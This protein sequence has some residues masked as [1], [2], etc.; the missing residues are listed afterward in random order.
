MEGEIMIKKSVLLLLI[1]AC[2]LSLT[3]CGGK[4]EG[5]GDKTQVNFWYGFGGPLGE[6]LE[7]M[8][9]D[10]NASHPDIQVKGVRVG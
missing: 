10:F 3:G 9:A 7:K 6:S 1:L 2:S 8:I 4:K 5:T